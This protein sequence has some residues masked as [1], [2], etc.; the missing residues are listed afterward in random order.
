LQCSARRLVV[1]RAAPDKDDDEP[2]GGNSKVQDD[3][4]DLISLEVAKAKVR[5]DMQKDLEQRKENMRKIGE[6]LME[7]LEKKIE[8][9]KMRM[10][11]ATSASLADTL[12]QFK[13]LDDEVQ[14]IRD[15][16]QADQA[17]LAAFEARSTSARNQGLFFQQLYKPDVTAGSDEP[18]AGAAGGAASGTSSSGSS[19]TLE[20]QVVRA[21]QHQITEPARR[22]LASPLRLYVFTYLAIVLACVVASDVGGGAPDLGLD[23]LYGV[24]CGLLGVNAWNERAA[25]AAQQQEVDE[26]KAQERQGQE[27]DGQGKQ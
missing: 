13:E 10:D 9:D 1:S 24:L 7:Q 26:H 4:V 23:A 20:P 22:E 25:L 16:L 3:L 15:E 18:G 19:S 12:Q 5:D 8:L 21:L 6:E 17:D 11:L 2:V 14:K 27:Q